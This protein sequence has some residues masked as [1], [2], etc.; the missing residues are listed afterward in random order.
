MDQPGQLGLPRKRFDG[1][2]Q[3][4]RPT[5]SGVRLAAPRRTL[6]SCSLPQRVGRERRRSRGRERGR[7]REE[8][9]FAGRRRE[10]S[11]RRVRSLERP[12]DRPTDSSTTTR[13]RSSLTL[14]RV[15]TLL[16]SA[17]Q[18]PRCYEA[19]RFSSELQNTLPVPL[20]LPQVSSNP[21]PK[22]PIPLVMNPLPLQ[23][24]HSCPPILGSPACTTRAFG[25]GRLTKGWVGAGE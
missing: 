6:S 22:N 20:H 25:G 23:F 18:A 17:K 13:P 24:K 9:A 3:S 12:S 19:C 16:H 11:A 10:T 4:G 21:I 15:H 8:G 14:L 2:R 5:L 1:T 7:G